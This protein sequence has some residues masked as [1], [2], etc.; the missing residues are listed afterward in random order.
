M[1]LVS[2]LRER[3]IFVTAITYPVI[4]LGLLMFRV[5]PTAAHTE[6][7]VETT[8]TRFKEMRDEMNLTLDM[9]GE[10]ETK[11]RKVFGL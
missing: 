8:I 5:I 7:D 11:V 4:P 2:F 3:G 10:D 6:E 9:T 1:R